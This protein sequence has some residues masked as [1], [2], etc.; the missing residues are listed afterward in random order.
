MES[1]RRASVAVVGAGV[2]GLA[3][4]RLL[5]RAGLSVTVFEAGDHPGGQVHTL[6]I[7]SGVHVDVGAEA[8]HLAAPGVIDLLEDLGLA[9][10]MVAARPLDGRL[11]TTRGLRPLPAGVGPAGPS[12]LGPVLRS[13]TLGWAALARAGLEPVVARA[14]RPLPA[15]RD[16]SV[17]DFVTRRFGRQVT[18]TFVDP[19]LGSLHAGDVGRLSLRACAPAL[20]PAATGRRSLVLRRP[21][22]H[23][24]LG[25]VSWPGG[26][27]EL[28]AALAGELDIRTGS[29]VTAVTARGDRFEVS[30]GV[31]STTV[32][33]VVL[34]LPAHPASK[35]LTDLSP[36]A[37][38]VLGSGEV[39]SVATVLISVDPAAARAHL[40][41]TGVLM[42][43]R[44]GRL[45]KAATHLSDKWPHLAGHEGY[46][47][48]LSAGRAGDDRLATLSDDE[49][50]S[51]LLRD[52]HEVTGL[53]AEPTRVVVRRWPAAL[54]QLTVGHL[55]RVCAARAALPDRVL[56]AGAAVDGVGLA[57]ALRS[58]SAAAA[59]LLRTEPQEVT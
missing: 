19:L 13:G 56:L 27:G 49:L 7:A 32:D 1:D 34:A 21:P 24:A 14:S 40:Q 8:L 25:F 55:D 20:V 48:R 47:V 30:T 39:A 36:A 11:L 59:S 41:G 31:T 2:S 43:S 52:L 9:N 5:Q 50:V 3:A 53:A 12:R 15:G 58:G 38:G 29:P 35:L 18:A 44:Q 28:V 37:A 45:L 46:W 4:A 42:P 10:S 22:R 51:H 57:S 26:L 23:P 16:V 54:P 6:E 17:G 33:A